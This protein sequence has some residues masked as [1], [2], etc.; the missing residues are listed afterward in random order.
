MK[1]NSM[2]S[3]AAMGALLLIDLNYVAAF[4]R[5]DILQAATRIEL[6]VFLLQL[7][8]TAVILGWKRLREAGTA[9]LVDVYGAEV[10][11]IPVLLVASFFVRPLAIDAAVSQLIRGWLAGAPFFA[12]PF[13]A[14]RLRRTMVRSGSLPNVLPTGIVAAEFGVL[15][16]NSSVSAAAGNTGLAGV[17]AFVSL[18][19]VSAV[20]SPYIFVSLTVLY[21]SLLVYAVLGLDSG[22][23]VDRNKALALGALATGLSLAWVTAFASL[24]FGPFSF[25]PLYLETT[26]IYALPTFAVAGF[27][28]WFARAR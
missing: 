7:A 28:W 14:Y 27:A 24:S 21:A 23:E 9:V 13:V 11:L 19:G 8:K 12:L 22:A 26:L 10:L 25:A 20:D 5:S 3:L 2:V 18:N 15:L 4:A 16:A 17:A 1:A 6:A